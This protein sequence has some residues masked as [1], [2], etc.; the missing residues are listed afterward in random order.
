MSKKKGF[1]AGIV[2]A[3]VAAVG[4]VVI[5]IRKREERY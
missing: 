4:A 2:A 1:V 5:L 3:V